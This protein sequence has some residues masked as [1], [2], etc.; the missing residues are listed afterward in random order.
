MR[1]RASAAGAG[2]ALAPVALLMVLVV[3]VAGCS[4]GQRVSL[5]GDRA[6][7]LIAA[8]AGEPDQLDPHK[9]TAYF[10]FEVL[11]NVFD[12]LVAPDAN[13]EM[14]PALAESWTVSPDQLT[15]TFRLRSG[16]TFHDGSPL[17]AEDVVYS[18]R[19]IIDER[20]ATA[21]RF[22][23]VADVRAAD[24]R[25]VVIRVHRPTPNLLTNIG[26]YKGMAIVSRRNVESGQI[27]TH[28]IGTGPFAFADRASGD[29][30]TL[31]ANAAYWGGRPGVAGV[32]FRFIPEPSTALSALQAGEIDW[33][34]SVPPQRVAQLRNDDSV[35]LAVTASNDYWYLALNNARRPWSDVRV[36]QAIA[37]AVDRDAIVQVTSYGT[38]EANQLAIPHGNPWFTDYHRYHRD[39]GTARELLAQAG[40]ERAELDMLVTADYPETVTAAQVIADN[41]APLGITVRIRTVDFATWLDEQN[42]GNFDMLMMGWLG[43]IDPDDFYY[44]QHHTNGTSNA[45]RFSDPQVDRLLDAGRVEMNHQARRRIYAEAATRIADQVSYVFLYNSAVIQAWSPA[46]TGFESRRDGA[47]RFRTATLAHGSAP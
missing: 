16:V 45:Q 46:L 37:Y 17:T 12:T 32:V 2:A 36:R 24:A 43:N 30:I 7:Y 29:S 11:E 15:W 13:L 35:R 20:L 9:T 28:P 18:Y 41:L 27:A 42:T 21:D 6:G 1:T 25:T 5:G 39:L 38:A 4:T 23:A 47:V 33:T 10:S 3:L 31:R 14:R 26:G 22:S 34:D 8:I 44:A 19:R 40:V